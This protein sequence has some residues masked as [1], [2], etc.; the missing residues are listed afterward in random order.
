[1]ETAGLLRGLACHLHILICC[2]FADYGR[3][4]SAELNLKF[5]QL[6]LCSSS[7]FCN[8][9]FLPN[10]PFKWQFVACRTTQNV[11]N[12]GT[13]P[14]KNLC[15]TGSKCISPHVYLLSNRQY[16]VLNQ[17]SDLMN[18]GGFKCLVL[19]QIL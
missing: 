5:L 18:C 14:L 17:K 6:S 9:S 19:G 4:T 13:K 15:R 8:N 1:M 7:L 11:N 10:L 3:L 16:E 12:F 2:V